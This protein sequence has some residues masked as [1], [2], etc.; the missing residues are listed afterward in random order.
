[1]AGKDILNIIAV[2]ALTGIVVISAAP[3][4]RQT[5]VLRPAFSV[6]LTKMMNVSDHVNVTFDRVFLNEGSGYDPM[7]GVFTAPYDGTYNFLYHALAEIDGVLYLDLYKNQEYISSAYAHVTS[8][9]G[10]ASNAVVIT[11]ARGDQVY[12]SGHGTSMLYGDAWEVYCTFS[13][14]LMF[15]T[16]GAPPA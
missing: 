6:G 5:E 16:K 12:I 13:G 8:D 2:L 11:L 3:E 7:T 9:Y 14:Y 4:K 15:F 10:S 1:M